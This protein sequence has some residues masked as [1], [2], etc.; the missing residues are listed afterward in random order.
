MGIIVSKSDDAKLYEDIN[1]EAQRLFRISDEIK[2]TIEKVIPK[3]YLNKSVE[4]YCIRCGIK[5]KMNPE[6]PYCLMDY[7]KW[8][9]FE[10]KTY[11]EK[12]GVCHMCGTPNNS[13]MEKPV[14]IECY[15]KNKKLFNNF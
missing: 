1:T 4:G 9:K 7:Q 13:S 11:T 10:D 12:T 2:V 3:E 14:C 5:I 15:K 6:H 8:N